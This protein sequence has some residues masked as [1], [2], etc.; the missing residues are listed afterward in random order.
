M[1]N[2]DVLLLPLFHTYEP[3]LCWWPEDSYDLLVVRRNVMFSKLAFVG[4]F[5]FHT[6]PVQY[7]TQNM[8]HVSTYIRK[9]LAGYNAGARAQSLHSMGCLSQLP[10]TIVSVEATQWYLLPKC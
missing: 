4:T 5:T 7:I 10:C 6:L 8:R 2:N 1:L 3:K 9:L